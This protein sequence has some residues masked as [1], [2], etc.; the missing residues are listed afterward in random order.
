MAEPVL[1][2]DIGGTKVAAALVADDGTVLADELRP[3]ASSLD[4]EVVFGSVAALLQR[5]PPA[6]P[7]EV[8]IGSAGPIDSSL[9]EVSPVNIPGWRGFPLLARVRDL[10]AAAT[11]VPVQVGL[12]GDGPCFA[13]GEHWLGAGRDV[14]AMVG[15]VL[16]TGVGAV[17]S[18]TAGCLR[19]APATPS[20]SVTSAW[21]FAVR[22]ASAGGTGASSCTPAVR[23]W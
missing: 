23:R 9:G 16:S 14:D 12:A 22:A 20:T 2:L 8:G 10:V 6:G 18:W 13:L 1:A 17:P 19:A 21:T 15:M 3:T 7:L 11:N 4:P 5:M